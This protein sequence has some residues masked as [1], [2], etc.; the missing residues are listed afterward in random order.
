MREP[1][2]SKLLFNDTSCPTNRFPWIF[3]SFVTIKE[4]STS[5]LFEKIDVPVPCICKFPFNERSELYEYN[6]S[7]YAPSPEERDSSKWSSS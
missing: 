7:T 6:V 3:E 2:K 5:T 1:L 4:E